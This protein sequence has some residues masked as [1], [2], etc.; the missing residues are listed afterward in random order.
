[1]Y[2]RV[3][4]KRDW[5][6]F[7]VRTGRMEACFVAKCSFRVSPE[8]LKYGFR[9]RIQYRQSFIIDFKIFIHSSKSF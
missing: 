7:V 1:M 4:I 8:E 2:I 9:L 5:I 6:N 3:F